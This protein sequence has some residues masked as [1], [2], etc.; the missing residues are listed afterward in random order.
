MNIKTL[1]NQAKKW[2][3][4]TVNA[5]AATTMSLACTSAYAAKGEYAIFSN[6]E[7]KDGTNVVGDN[8]LIPALIVGGVCAAWGLM[9]WMTWADSKRWYLPVGGLIF[10]YYMGNGFEWGV[11]KFTSKEA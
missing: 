7:I 1:F 4:A 11:D 2:S 8:L 5:V 6:D 9:M 10:A 3:K